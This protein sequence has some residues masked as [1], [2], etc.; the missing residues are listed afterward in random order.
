MRN[1]LALIY[2][3]LAVVGCSGGQVTDIRSEADGRDIVHGRIEW[4]AG[5]ARFECLASGTGQCHF[6]LFDPSCTDPAAACGKPPER[7]VLARGTSREIV[8]LPAGFRP[9]VSAEGEAAQPDCKI[10]H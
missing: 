9:C 1:A 3:L 10:A 2:Y 5:V 7:F 4:R 8:G 6:A